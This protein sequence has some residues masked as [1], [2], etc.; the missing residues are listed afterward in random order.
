[1]GCCHVFNIFS[2]FLLFGNAIMALSILL[3]QSKME[4]I[5]SKEACRLREKMGVQFFHTMAVTNCLNRHFVHF[6]FWH[7]CFN[8]FNWLY[9]CVGGNVDLYETESLSNMRY[10]G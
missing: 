4:R 1:M 3:L 9:S 8:I 5:V 6:E 2:C 10:R 7:I